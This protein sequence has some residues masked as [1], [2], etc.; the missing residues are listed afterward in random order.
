MLRAAQRLPREAQLV[1]LAGAPDTPE[2][3]AEVE[4]LVADL[5]RDR[6]GG[7][8][9]IQEMLPKREVI[10]VLTHA[11]TF[12][13]PSIYE[14]LGIVNLEAM[15]C[16]TSVVASDVGGIP[17]VVADGETGLL[18][19]YDACD[20]EGFE[21]GLADGVNAVIADPAR[22]KAFG[23]AGRARA[24]RE[25]AWSAVAGRTLEI[26]ESLLAER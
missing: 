14:P 8:I 26:Y 1:F 19:P 6:E 18:V 9:W 13:C 23:L 10:Q 24:V 21:R 15:A 20:P 17:E 4:A 3:A 5:R 2:I 22:A 12:V 16:E 11:T 25:F 7:V